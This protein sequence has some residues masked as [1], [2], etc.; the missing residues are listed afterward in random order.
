MAEH[1]KTRQ[2]NAP[3]DFIDVY[4][5]KLDTIKDAENSPFDG[6][7]IINKVLE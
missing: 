7:E 4:L 3:R 1:K 2:S 6:I 5:E